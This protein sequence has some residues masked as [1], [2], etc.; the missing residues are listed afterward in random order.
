MAELR[1]AIGKT[2]L[3]LIAGEETGKQDVGDVRYKR[4]RLWI[5]QLPE[6]VCKEQFRFGELPLKKSRASVFEKE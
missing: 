4:A 3:F 5:G 6:T 1:E 2:G